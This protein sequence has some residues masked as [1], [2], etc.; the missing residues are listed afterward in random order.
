[1]NHPLTDLRRKAIAPPM[2][3]A[4]MTASAISLN[5]PLAAAQ[6]AEKSV[7]AEPVP[8][9]PAFNQWLSNLPFAPPPVLS[10]GI[11]T[12]PWPAAA[13]GPSSAPFE[14]AAVILGSP[15]LP[16]LGAGRAGVRTWGHQFNYQGA[17]VKLLVIDA[18]GRKLE[19]RSLGT[20][21]RPGERFKIRVTPTFDAVADLTLVLGDAWTSQRAGQLYPEAGL[22]VQVKAGETV[23]LPLEVNQYFVLG[24]NDTDRV[25]LSLRHPQALGD[26]RSAQPAY[27]QDMRGGTGYLQLVPRGTH[28][29]IDLLLSA[30]R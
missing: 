5:V 21:P 23:D 15:E 13:Q 12:L 9:V 3:L 4:M 10:P 16:L 14:P 17:Q 30:A 1:M 26:A 18:T 7:V 20:M 25:L 2:L 28:P 27:R 11:A 19:V 8:V 6:D 24:P 29:A 22:S